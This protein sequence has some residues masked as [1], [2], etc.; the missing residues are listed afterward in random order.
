MRL[1]RTVQCSK[2]ISRKT[3]TAS[4]K[5]TRRNSNYR[6]RKAKW[7]RNIRR[8]HG[9]D[10]RF[11]ATRRRIYVIGK[12][13]YF[14]SDVFLSIKTNPATRRYSPLDNWQGRA[15]EHCVNEEPADKSSK[16][17]YIW[18]WCFFLVTI[19]HEY[20]VPERIFFEL[21]VC[22][23][24]ALYTHT[25]NGIYYFF[26]IAAAVSSEINTHIIFYGRHTIRHHV[27]Y[28]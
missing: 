25:H 19:R 27:L 3:K 23:R 18:S 28:S 1:Y 17:H 15:L 6:F 26:F 8:G 21:Y 14:S 12:L 9:G 22:V 5:I 13:E 16:R 10:R 7:V 4:S 20:T 11:V 2:L 24:Y